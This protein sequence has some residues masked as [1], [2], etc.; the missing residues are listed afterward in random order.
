MKKTY[1]LLLFFAIGFVACKQKSEAW[2]EDKEGIKALLKEKKA[3]LVSLQN[4]IDRLNDELLEID[5]PKEEKVLV[6]TTVLRADTLL[7]YSS[8]QGNVA[9]DDIVFASSETGGRLIN[10]RVKEG[11]YV[12]RGAFIASVDLS[13]V[14]KQMDEL[15]TALD[16]ANT[17]YERQ[18]RLWDQEIGSEMQFLSAK[19]GKERLE[20]SIAT[21][22]N[23]LAKANVYAPTSGV[24][25]TKFLQTGELAGPGAPIVKILNT[26]KLKVVADVPESYL[27]SL[28]NRDKV[29]L[30]FPALDKTV[31]SKITLLGK[32]IDPS[33]RTFKIE[34][35]VSNAKGDL[36]PN[37]L[38]EVKINDLNLENVIVIPVN[39][40][41]EDVNGNQYVYIAERKEDKKHAK[42]TFIQTSESADGEIVV[43][44]GLKI[45]DELVTVGGSGVRE[46]SLLMISNQE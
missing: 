7:R 25:E 34:A 13:S 35:A 32:T 24:I 30:Y 37:L 1:L 11:Q 27:K 29:E 20:K 39:I 40:I 38:T 17:T 16:L 10:V 26:S 12:K 9:S 8:I 14:E 22:Q 3:S 23:Q 19:N 18:K 15:R 2:P 6:S 44:E 42:K 4:D 43:V 21:L 41:E 46:N 36:K 33:N 31:S 28:K 45:G 5:P